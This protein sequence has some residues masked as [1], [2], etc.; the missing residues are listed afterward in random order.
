MSL[1]TIDISGLSISDLKKLK[2]MATNDTSIRLIDDELDGR[3]EIENTR[4]NESFIKKAPRRNEKLEIVRLR[5][6][7][8]MSYTDIS[9]KLRISTPTVRDTYLRAKK[10]MAIQ[11]EYPD[12]FILK[13]FID[14]S[15]DETRVFNALKRADLLKNNRWLTLTKEE[16][17]M[18]RNVGDVNSDFVLATQKAYY[19]KCD[20]EETL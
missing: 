18:M 6:E 14:F 10:R 20:K 17:M 8:G 16:L 13:D 9:F 11:K 12:F 4:R 2:R 15:A 3:L 1:V 7:E 5:D 19:E